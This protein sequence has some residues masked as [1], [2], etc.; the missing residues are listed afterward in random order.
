MVIVT[1]TTSKR[2]DGPFRR[3]ILV[4][5]DLNANDREVLKSKGGN[6]DTLNEIEITKAHDRY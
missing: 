3:K 6:F 2:H 1:T 4:L 5:V